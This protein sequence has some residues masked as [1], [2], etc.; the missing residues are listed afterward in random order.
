[1]VGNCCLG[2]PGPLEAVPLVFRDLLE[3]ARGQHRQG[4][5]AEDA[6]HDQARDVGGRASGQAVPTAAKAV[7]CEGLPPLVLLDR[8]QQHEAAGDEGA[9][10]DG[11]SGAEAR[12]DE[13]VAGPV[14]RDNAAAV[15][16]D[17]AC[18]E[19]DPAGEQA[20]QGAAAV[21]AAGGHK[22]AA[23]RAGE[24]RPDGPEHRKAGL[25]RRG[26]WK[27]VGFG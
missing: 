5:R 9:R 19:A 8:V 27:L 17:P 3:D 21:P 1:M 15:L 26:L 25:G 11:A 4:G 20:E 13:G 2:E 10:E 12:D 23:D 7:A 22:Q 6:G 16:E 14:R 18:S 24:G